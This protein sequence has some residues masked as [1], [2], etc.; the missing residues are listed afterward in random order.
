MKH[1]SISTTEEELA[2]IRRQVA[3]LVE[4]YIRADRIARE[5]EAFR[6]GDFGITL[7]VK[8]KEGLPR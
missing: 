8:G 5:K 1:H 6:T 4:S 3:G 7:R 2:E